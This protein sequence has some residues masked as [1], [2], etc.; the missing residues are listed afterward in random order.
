MTYIFRI[1]LFYFI[2][3]ATL[4][5]ALLT[6][7]NEKET[8]YPNP[9]GYDLAKP[10][11]MKLPAELDEISG[12]AYYPKDSSIFAIN[13]ERGWLYKI[14]PQY[15]G[16]IEKWKF[17]DGADFEDLVLLDSTFYVLVSNGNIIAFHHFTAD[18]LIAKENIFPD[19]SGNE[20]E[21]LYY[22]PSIKKLV[23]ICKDCESDKKKYLSSF[24]FDPYTEE[25]SS[26]TLTIDVKRIAGMMNE[27]KMKFK[28]S[29]ATIDPLTGDIY[30]LS[31]V[32]NLLVI[33]D[34]EGKAKGVYP[35]N[36]ALF[37][38]PEGIA[39]SPSGS[40]IV[41]NE[42]ADIGVANIL[43]YNLLATHIKQKK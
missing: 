17:Y 2:A 42:A 14:Y 27:K 22:D 6:S 10:F 11:E 13:D 19:K 9:P 43:I 4:L 40:L 26:H 34:R 36:P 21:I 8:V 25:Y 16:R 28:P 31:A 1:R 7:C 18:S 24:V 20:F 23:L 37:K 32:N 38:Q 39:F 15:P 35:I 3:S 41:S 29:A 5:I 33:T 12:L 30:I